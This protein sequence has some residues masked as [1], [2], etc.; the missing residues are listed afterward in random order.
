MS[1]LF[2]ILEV[3][4]YIAI[5]VAIFHLFV[6]IISNP[7]GFLLLV[8]Y[9][10]I[11]LFIRLNYLWDMFSA[12]E[13]IFLPNPLSPSGFIYEVLADT[14]GRNLDSLFGIKFFADAFAWILGAIDYV[15]VLTGILYLFYYFFLSRLAG[16]YRGWWKAA[17][18]FVLWLI[19]F[20]QLFYLRGFKSWGLDFLARPDEMTKYCPYFTSYYWIS[21]VLSLIYVLAD[22]KK[23]AY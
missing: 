10:G 14:V 21:M 7:W 3:V 4:F 16:R 22:I 5:L 13:H 17:L 19:I 8:L 15:L 12:T 20:H 23:R 11:L 9:P 6:K 2:G 1:F 18:L